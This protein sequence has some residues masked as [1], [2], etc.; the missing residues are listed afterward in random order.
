MLIGGTGSEPSCPCQNYRQ[1]LNQLPGRLGILNTSHVASAGGQWRVK[2]EHSPSVVAKEIHVYRP[3]HVFDSYTHAPIFCINIWSSRI[4]FLC[5]LQGGPF[6]GTVVFSFRKL[7][8]HCV[9]LCRYSLFLFTAS[10]LLRFSVFPC[11]FG[12][13]LL[14]VFCSCFSLFFCLFFFFCYFS[15]FSTF[16]SLFVLGFSGFPTTTRKGA[17][18]IRF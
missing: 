17:K 9:Q 16:F 13:L 6:W 18:N 3:L 11:F 10:P 15:L 12:F 2:P 8:L 4:L 7:L 1:S 14:S 5:F